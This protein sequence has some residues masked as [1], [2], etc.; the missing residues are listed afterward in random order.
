MLIQL[1]DHWIRRHAFGRPGNAW[2]YKRPD[3][4]NDVDVALVGEG[5]RTYNDEFR[6]FSSR[7]IVIQ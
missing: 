1:G 2:Q 7:K 3:T 5:W 4:Y 6:I